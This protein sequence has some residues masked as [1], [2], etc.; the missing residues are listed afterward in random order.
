MT[1]SPDFEA[2]AFL[3]VKDSENAVL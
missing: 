3:R 2:A 1:L